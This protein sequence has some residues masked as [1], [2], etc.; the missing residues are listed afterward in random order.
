MPRSTPV[1]KLD[2]RVAR[3][4]RKRR[5]RREKVLAAARRVFSEKGYHAASITDIIEAAGIARGTFYLYF[6]SK[7]AIFAELLDHFFLH[8]KREVRVVDVSA[9]AP[10]PRTQLHVIVRDVLQT[11]IDNRDLTRILL[12]EALGVDDDFDRK[13]A[14]FYDRLL[15]LVRHSLQTGQSLG[16]VR[17]LDATIVSHC[18]VGSVKELADHLILRSESGQS[19]DLDAVTRQAL[20]FNLYGVL[21]GK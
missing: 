16:L 5:E 14:D 21:Q 10:A 17:T 19:I 18:I 15:E 1:L 9:G 11:L 7:R 13:L 4:E 20:E 12:R 8:L 6:E 2:G 3:A